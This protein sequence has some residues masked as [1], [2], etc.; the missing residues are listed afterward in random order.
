MEPIATLGL[1]RA[2]KGTITK[3][4]SNY[5]YLAKFSSFL[6]QTVGG[7]FF[8]FLQNFF[9]FGSTPMCVSLYLNNKIVTQS[10]LILNLCNFLI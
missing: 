7:L 4:N 1:T 9:Y 3:T 5:E 8:V 10:L 6:G 2:K